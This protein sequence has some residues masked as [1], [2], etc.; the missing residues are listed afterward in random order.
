[1]ETYSLTGFQSKREVGVLVSPQYVQISSR[2][3]VRYCCW[4]VRCEG[5]VSFLFHCFCQTRQFLV[6]FKLL[7]GRSSPVYLQRPLSLM[8]NNT[9]AEHPS[10]IPIFLRTIL[11]LCN[12]FSYFEKSKRMT[13]PLHLTSSP[14]S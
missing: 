11:P 3:K 10:N 12:V 13:I 2:L 14:N 6:E 4:K 1:M 9:T 5:I 8:L 7:E